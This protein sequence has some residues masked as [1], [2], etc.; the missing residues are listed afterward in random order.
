MAADSALCNS[1]PLPYCLGFLIPQQSIKVSIKKKKKEVLAGSTRV[2]ILGKG[3]VRVCSP[4]AHA[5]DGS[6]LG[7]SIPRPRVG[8]IEVISGD[9]VADACS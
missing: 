9:K 1:G 4:H 7:S 5:R 8:R 3:S 6:G 2:Y